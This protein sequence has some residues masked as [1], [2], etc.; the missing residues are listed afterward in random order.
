MLCKIA[1]VGEA[2]G[3]HEERQQQAFVGPSGWE[4]MKMLGEAGIR[5][6]ECYLTNVFNLR[7]RPTNDII[8]LCADA[9]PADTG[10]LPSLQRGKYL[11]PEYLPQVNRLYAEL[12]RVRP[13]LT[14]AV[15]NTATWALLLNTGIAKL[16]GVVQAAT[17]SKVAGLKVLPTYHPAV[18]FKGPDSWG[19][20]PIIVMDLRKA[21][22]ESEFPD[23][24]RPERTIY[25]EPSLRDLEWFYETHLRNANEIT[26]DIETSGDIITC[27]GFAPSPSIAI[28]IPFSDPRNPSG[29]YWPT[30]EDDVAAWHF[31]QRVLALP[32]GKSAQNGLYDITFLWKQY[33]ITVNNF[34]EDTMLLHHALQ[35][36]SEK[37]LGFLGSIYTNE[38]AWKTMR[39][40]AKDDTI[41]RE[42]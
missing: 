3:E 42:Q 35:P 34:D 14:I 30:A 16:R 26:F 10:G 2:W 22:R 21:R 1:I 13:N 9:R 25:T 5:R 39:K 12:S 27:I 28:V 4:L 15:G 8:N 40:R 17:A 41:K 24:R 38:A 33:G 18:L 6:S 7:P 11:R 37:G 31:V 20:R 23:V 36:E 29:C 32:C 19:I